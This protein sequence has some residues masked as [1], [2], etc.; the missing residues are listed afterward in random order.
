MSVCLP[1]EEGSHC[2]V[3]GIKK[4]VTLSASDPTTGSQYGGKEGREGL[5]KG[6]TV[7]RTQCQYRVEEMFRV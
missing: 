2:G 3:P 6:Q 7:S 5:K 1:P 4:G